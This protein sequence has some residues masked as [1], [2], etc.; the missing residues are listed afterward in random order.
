MAVFGLRVSAS[1]SKFWQ[2]LVRICRPNKFQASSTWPMEK[3]QFPNNSPC[4]V[5]L[6]RGIQPTTW[7]SHSVTCLCL[8]VCVSVC[9][10]W[11]RL[12]VSI[13]DM[14]I[15]W[16]QGTPQGFFFFGGG[17]IGLVVFSGDSTMPVSGNLL[18]RFSPRVTFRMKRSSESSWARRRAD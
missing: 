7:N 1:C 14:H 12:K 10:V 18:V 6:S 3:Y 9:V 13:P 11:S 2:S 15:D 5:S 8:C 4:L 16:I 17:L